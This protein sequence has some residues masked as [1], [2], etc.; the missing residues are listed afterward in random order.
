MKLLILT[1]KV[2]KNDET[3][4]FFYDWIME[5]SRH[6]EKVTVIGLGVG[7]Y[8][9]P[10]NVRVL[11][12]GKEE[13]AA[14]RGSL[15]IFKKIKYI[16]NFFKY[17]WQYRRDYD[18]VFIHMNPEYAV[19][20]GWFWRLWKKR[21]ALWYVH[22]QNSWRLWLAEK[23]CQVVFSVGQASLPL[24]G[25]KINLVGHGIN[26]EKFIY[27]PK[28]GN[29]DKFKIISVGRLTKIK[30]LA[31]L[32]LAIGLLPLELRGRLSVEL[33]GA[34]VT[35]A[36][37]SYKNSLMAQIEKEKLAEVIKFVG[38]SPYLL[39]PEV[40]RRADLMVNLAP[41]G[42]VDKAVL[43][44]M[45]CG[46]PVLVANESFRPYLGELA[47]QLIFKFGDA[48]DLAQKITWLSQQKLDPFFFRQQVLNE[49][50]LSQLIKKITAAIEKNPLPR[51]L[52]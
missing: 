35:A 26:C 48:S 33:V 43:E 38:S 11:S 24:R 25:K 39:M 44:A 21:L 13:L 2:D 31:T 50:N 10:D 36:D 9:L 17:T 40:Y 52:F 47:Q 19:L 3:L 23:L 49:H 30:D 6:C 34:P 29:D 42:G 12:L 8:H 18:S 20:G 7:E 41:T 37:D 16:F 14:G 15:D 32:I 4:G 22:R 27:Q 28:V 46:L 51:K 5:F 1:Q 45:A